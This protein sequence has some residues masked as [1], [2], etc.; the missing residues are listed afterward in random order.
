MN[1]DEIVALCKE[2]FDIKTENEVTID[3]LISFEI[4]K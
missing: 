3:S 2:Y 4:P 1:L